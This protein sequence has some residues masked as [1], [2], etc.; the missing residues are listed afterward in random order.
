M[1]IHSVYQSLRGRGVENVVFGTSS[2]LKAIYHRAEKK[3]SVVRYLLLGLYPR[4]KEGKKFREL[5]L[6][7]G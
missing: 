7:I 4:V 2:L 5:R 3:S 1:G 6:L